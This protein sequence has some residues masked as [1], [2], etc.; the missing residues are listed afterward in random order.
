MRESAAQKNCAILAVHPRALEL[1]SR[2]HI[3]R[4][5]SLPPGYSWQQS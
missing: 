1:G 4:C 3:R 2:Q 5:G